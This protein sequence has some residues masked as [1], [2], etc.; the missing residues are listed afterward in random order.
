MSNG[1]RV[2]VTGG[3]G[4]LGSHLPN[5]SSIGDMTFSA[6]ITSSLARVIM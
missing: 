1:K 5:V 2:L 4:F 3:A 6:S